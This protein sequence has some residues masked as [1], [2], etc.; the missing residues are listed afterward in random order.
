MQKAVVLFVM[1]LRDGMGSGEGEE[2]VGELSRL[3]TFRPQVWSI[4]ITASQKL[5]IPKMDVLI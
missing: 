4:W 1:L 5:A 2:V 3:S